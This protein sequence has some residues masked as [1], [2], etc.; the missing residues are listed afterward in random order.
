MFSRFLEKLR[1]GQTFT[2]PHLMDTLRKI[3]TSSPAPLLLTEVPDFKAYCD[4]YICDGQEALIGH[5]K[6]LLFRFFME[7]D[8]PIMQYKAHA[9][10]PSWSNSIC[11]WKTDSEGKPRLPKG[12][13]PLLAMAEHIKM[14]EEVISRLKGYIKF[15]QNLSNGSF[16]PR[17]YRPVIDYWSNVIKEIGKPR[18]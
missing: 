6:P 4:G 16:V 14:Y 2:L 12:D 18:H 10:I 8:T 3:S 9:A 7:G 15:W 11:L 1:V 5:S 17:Y 13:P